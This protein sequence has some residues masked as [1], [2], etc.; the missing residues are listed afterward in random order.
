M[1]TYII[2]T[3]SGTFQAN[4]GINWT[5]YR[6]EQSLDIPNPVRQVNDEVQALL[7]AL[8]LPGSHFHPAVFFGSMTKR[9]EVDSSGLLW[10]AQ[11]GRLL[12]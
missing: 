6:D 10:R 3:E 8:E 12:N 1:K 5:Q 4:P 2:N 9:V 7:E 11:S